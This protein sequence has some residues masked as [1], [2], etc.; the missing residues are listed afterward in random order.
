M[1]GLLFYYET[2]LFCLSTQFLGQIPRPEVP[3]IHKYLYPQSSWYPEPARDACF[4]QSIIYPDKQSVAVAVVI[5]I[6]S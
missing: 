6:V 2:R 1:H 5:V 3:K 4:R